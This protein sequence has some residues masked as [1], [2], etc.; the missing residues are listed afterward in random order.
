MPHAECCHIQCLRGPAAAG[1]PM[2]R[3]PL[4]ADDTYLL[5]VPRFGGP[6]LALLLVVPLAL[7]LWLY[8][9]ELKLIHRLPAL[10]LLGLRCVV[11][12]LLWLIAG[13]QPTVARYHEED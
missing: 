9:Y 4:P 11:L 8:R 12:V 2:F 13:L 10:V 7:V 6:A 5:L 1:D 3:V